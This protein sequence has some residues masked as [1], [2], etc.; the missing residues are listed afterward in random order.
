MLMVTEIRSFKKHAIFL[1]G[2]ALGA[3]G[4][5]YSWY[6]TVYSDASNTGYGGYLINYMR[7][8]N[9]KWKLFI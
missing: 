4:G 2:L 5:A 8:K 9:T 3:E 1:K 6:F 7:D